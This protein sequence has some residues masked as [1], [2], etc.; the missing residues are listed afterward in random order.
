MTQSLKVFFAFLASVES[1]AVIVSGFIQ[2]ILPCW[3]L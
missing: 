1:F 2:N 3:N